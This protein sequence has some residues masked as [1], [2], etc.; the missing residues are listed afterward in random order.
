M[1]FD[2]HCHLDDN[3]FD[4]DRELIL[5]DMEAQGLTPCVTIGAN[6]ETSK[7]CKTIADT[8]P[9][10]FF[11]AGV[12][13]HD[14][15]EYCDSVHAEIL[16]LVKEP[17][18]VA[19]GEIG[20]DYYYDFSPRDV[21]REVFIRQLESAHQINKTTVF[22][23]RDAHE[24]ALCIFRER[25]DKLPNGIM[26]CFSGSTEQA[27]VYLDMGFYISLAGPVTF[28]NARNLKA[29]AAFVPSDRLLLETDSPYLSPE[30]VRGKRNDPRNMV[31]IAKI[32]AA[33]RSMPYEELCATCRSNGIEA[34]GM[35]LS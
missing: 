10:L 8:R 25:K 18:C 27:K 9:W 13:P 6:L 24:D 7:T 11:A 17:K 23:V 28:S 19:W 26:H 2:T 29:V 1:L 16:S 33:L 14:A 21:Q 30:P 12:H 34:F 4:S 22:H 35:V 5:N 3:R 32:V 31:H 15:K 20:L